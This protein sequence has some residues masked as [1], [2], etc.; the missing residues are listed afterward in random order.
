MKKLNWEKKFDEQW[1]DTNH[2]IV[3]GPWVKDA[4]KKILKDQRKEIAREGIKVFEKMEKE[5]IDILEQ[6]R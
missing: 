2:Y 1:E 4:I 5:I 6:L 3:W